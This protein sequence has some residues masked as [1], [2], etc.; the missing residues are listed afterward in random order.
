[1]RDIDF[2]YVDFISFNLIEIF[3]KNKNF[4]WSLEY[5]LNIYIYNLV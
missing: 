4:S 5:F 2:S 1:M 3:I